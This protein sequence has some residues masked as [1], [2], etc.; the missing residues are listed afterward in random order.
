VFLTLR[1]PFRPLSAGALYH[2]TRSRFD[3]LGID[4]PHRGPHAL[5]HACACHLLAEGASL[6]VISDHLGHRSLSSTRHYA[7]VDLPGLREVARFD[8]GGLL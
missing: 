8:L 4:T 3:H 7:K 1:A 6:E 5:R 2:V